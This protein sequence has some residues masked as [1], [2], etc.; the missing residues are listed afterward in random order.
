MRRGAM[1]IQ[2]GKVILSLDEL[3]QLYRYILTHCR[4]ICPQIRNPETCILVSKIG[5]L[6][7]S[8]PPC[9]E[10]YGSFTKETFQK[11]VAEIEQ[12]YGMPIEK[13]VEK[14]EKEGPQNLQEHIDLIDGRFALE[15]VR[16]Y[17]KMENLQETNRQHRRR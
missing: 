15:V 10:D 3:K 17:E 14:V 12:R 11:L 8:P 9:F 13:F 2:N 6:L 1:E 5:V 7:K 4:E 16:A